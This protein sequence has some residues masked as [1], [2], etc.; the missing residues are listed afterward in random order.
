MSTAIRRRDNE[1]PANGPAAIADAPAR[2][3]TLA[4]K[5]LNDAV[6]AHVV[7]LATRHGSTTAPAA[8]YVHFANGTAR[9][10]GLP[11]SDATVAAAMPIEDRAILALIRQGVAARIP[12]WAAQ[13]EKE[14]GVKPH[15]RVRLLAEAWALTE[16][17]ALRACGLADVIAKAEGLLALEAPID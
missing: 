2:A 9:A 5:R 1:H 17:K 11:R 6:H 16:A 10:I 3:L 15:N 8:R 13:V 4:T 14:G 12:A 7:K